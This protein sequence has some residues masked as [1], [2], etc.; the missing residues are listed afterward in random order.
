MIRKPEVNRFINRGKCNKNTELKMKTSKTIEV[1][2][3]GTLKRKMKNENKY[4][5]GG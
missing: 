1:F 2:T 3:T 5:T 4:N